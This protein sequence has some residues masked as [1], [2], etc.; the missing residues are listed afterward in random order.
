VTSEGSASD[1]PTARTSDPQRSEFVS[2]HALRVAYDVTSLLDA[3]TGVGTFADEVLRRCAAMDDIDVVGYSVSWRGRRAIDA[4]LPDG[5]RKARGPMAAQPL[6]RLWQRTDWPPIE[7]WT[8]PADLVHG[9]NFVVPP[10]KRG[11]VELATVHD[12]TCV[13]FPELC[14]PDTLQYPGLIRRA[15][16]RGAH[17]HAVSQFVADEVIDVFSVEP[18]RVHVV[19]NGI[20]PVSEGNADAG[21]ARVAANRYILAVGTIE[22]RKDLPLLVEAFDQLAATQD[23]VCLV[24]A[25]QDGWGSEAFAAAVERAQHGDR[26]I[27]TGWVDDRGRADLLAGAQVFAYPSK[28]EGFGLAPLEAMTAGT[29]VVTTR[30]GALPEVL[31]DAARFV[32]PGD[33]DDLAGALAS[34]LDDSAERERLVDAGRVRSQQYSW[35]ACAQ[36]VVNLYRRLC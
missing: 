20:D 3:R 1:E 35:D 12:L 28:Y 23:D 30:A 2:K 15:L 36:G 32:A 25:G 11:T 16:A 17:I 31:G 13:R 26:V 9:P 27:C 7:W 21:R 10:A 6:R 29:P 5:V 8:G 4:L 34:L 24:V 14:T 22:P 33:V 19:P 18:D